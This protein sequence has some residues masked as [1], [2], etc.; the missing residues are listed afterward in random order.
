MTE[1]AKYSPATLQGDTQKLLAMIAEE[2]YD[3]KVEHLMTMLGLLAS[4]I[5][6]GAVSNPDAQRMVATQ[7]NKAMLDC[8]DQAQRLAAKQKDAD[9]G[10]AA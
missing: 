3:C 5:L 1:E 9:G 6:I 4:S 8:I 2:F 10:S 7:F